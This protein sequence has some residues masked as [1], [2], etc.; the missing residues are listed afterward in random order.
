MISK[1]GIYIYI[2]CIQ[3]NLIYVLLFDVLTVYIYKY[4]H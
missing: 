2:L 3:I 4:Q 1:E